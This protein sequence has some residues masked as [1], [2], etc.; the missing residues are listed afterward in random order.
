M[1][2]FSGERR[3]EPVDELHEDQTDR[4]S[5]GWQSIAARAGQLFDKALGAQF[6]EVVAERAETVSVLRCR[7]VRR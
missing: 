3:A 6:G 4:I 7:P 5:L 1:E 2:E